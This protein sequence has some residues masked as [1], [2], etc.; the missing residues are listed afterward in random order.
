MYTF[1]TFFVYFF[2]DMDWDQFSFF[3][4]IFQKKVDQDGLFPFKKNLMTGQTPSLYSQQE[5]KTF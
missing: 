2:F 1:G 4:A 5:N 3:P